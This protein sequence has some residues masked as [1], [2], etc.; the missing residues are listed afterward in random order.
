MSLKVGGW[1]VDFIIYQVE[2]ICCL[3]QGK[4]EHNGINCFL[5]KYSYFYSTVFLLYFYEVQVYIKF[6][7]SEK[8]AT[9]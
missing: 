5:Y 4:E 3:R 2:K 1:A 8:D 7:Y 6:R 9:I